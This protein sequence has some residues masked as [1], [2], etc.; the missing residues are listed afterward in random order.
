MLKLSK[1]KKFIKNLYGM[2][3]TFVLQNTVRCTIGDNEGIMGTQFRNVKVT[4]SAS[5]ETPIS[6]MVALDAEISFSSESRNTG[7]SSSNSWL[8]DI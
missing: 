6:K 3:I 7:T 1:A 2:V 8:I 4:K 5:T